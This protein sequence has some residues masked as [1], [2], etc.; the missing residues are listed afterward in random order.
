MDIVHKLQK[1][2]GTGT[3]SGTCIGTCIGSGIGTGIG[4]GTGIGE[5][6]Q[7][8]NYWLTTYG[9][10]RFPD[11]IYVPDNNEL[12]NVILRDFHEKTYLGHPGYQNTLTIVKRY[13][14]WRNLKRDVAMFV[15]R[16][17]DCQ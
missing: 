14:Y 10:V 3:G 6:A 8:T 13:Y 12:K 15:E 11:N 4:M 9:L 1:S 16:C 5:S 2:T 17:F 7:G